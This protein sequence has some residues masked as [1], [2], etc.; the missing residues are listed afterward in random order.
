V[1]TFLN[2]T[3]SVLFES[4]YARFRSLQLLEVG[5][6]KTPKGGLDSESALSSPPEQRKEEGS[7]R[8]SGK[9]K[10]KRRPSRSK[11]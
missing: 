9:S 10:I 2:V 3:G 4:L 8:V 1:I 11:R 6:S 5:G 7:R